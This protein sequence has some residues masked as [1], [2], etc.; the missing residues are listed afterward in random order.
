VTQWYR[1][2]TFS[3]TNGSP[4]ITGALTAWNSLAYE[5]DIFRDVS[6]GALYEIGTVG[7]D[8]SITLTTNYAGSTGSAKTYEIIP[9][10]PA[11]NLIAN[12]SLQLSDLTEAVRLGFQ[13]TST[14]SVAIGTGSKVF[15]VQSGVPILPG[16]TVRIAS[17]ANL[18][19]NNM[20]GT[21][22]A[23]SGTTLTVN[24]ATT[25]GSG[26]YTDWNINI[27][28]VQGATGGA[29]PANSLAIGTV[30]TLTA[31]SSATASVTGTPP[32]QTLNLGIP[33]GQDAT[34]LTD[35]DKGDITVAGTG[36]TWTIDPG[37]VTNAKMANMAA[38]TVKGNATNAAAAPTD[39]AASA[40]GHVLRRN[41]TGLD[42]GPV[43]TAGLSDDA[44]TNAKLANMATQTI[45]GR[46]TAG[47]GDPEDLTPAQVRSIVGGRETLTAARTYFV[48]TD[49][50][51]SNTGLA[52]NSGGAF[53]TVQKAIDT[54][55]S[56]DSSIYDVT[57][58]VADGTYS[59]STGLTAKNMAG[60]GK[61][62]IQGNSGTPSNVV[63]TTNGAMTTNNACLLVRGISTVYQF[64]DFRVNSTASGTVFGILATAGSVVE[65][66]GIDFGSGMA[67]QIRVVDSAV[68]T[69]VGNYS[70]SGGST[71]HWVCLGNGVLRCQ[72]FTVTLTGTPAQLFV[73]AQF[74]G[75]V[76]ATSITFSGAATGSR[77]SVTDGGIINTAGAGTS[78]FP[79]NSAGTGTNFS[80]SP[81]GLYV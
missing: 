2:G 39:I 57:I 51:D 29:G 74:G 17:R 6:T 75:V 80:A 7:S 34:G 28:G 4:T 53:L 67:Q 58:Q 19:T 21:V 13:M 37:A 25:N 18:T 77:Y 44:V 20:S 78:Y 30:T 81:F 15:T 76:F 69:C 11:R 14:S 71:T 8:T 62:I 43:V 27:A 63:I 52:N 65:W 55:A 64:K 32:S 35:G 54:A 40:D 1:T 9:T 73:Q 61:I 41:G 3:A 10:S 70:I 72:S 46:T 48:R 36:T 49:G 66:S 50:S 26:T 68:A 79:G 5:G 56:L 31:G 33:R 16:A 23:Y 12:L 38:L 42:F 60:A 22:T 59:T 45:K 47:T 24:V